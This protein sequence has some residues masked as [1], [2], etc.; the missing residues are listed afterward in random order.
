MSLIDD[1]KVSLRVVSDMTDVEVQGLIDAAMQDM[2]R[3]GIRAALLGDPMNPLAKSAVV[4]FCKASYGF[5]NS[6]SDRYWQRYHWAVTA[7]MN[8]SANEAAEVAT[9]AFD[10]LSEPE[11]SPEPEPD[12]SPEPDTEPEGGDGA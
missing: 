4:M 1:V 11:P 10:E 2:R 7:L 3:V 6:D 5:D 8:S 9:A 12:P